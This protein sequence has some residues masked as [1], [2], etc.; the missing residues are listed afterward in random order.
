[1]HDFR[2]LF[3]FAVKV[4]NVLVLMF[5]FLMASKATSQNVTFSDSISI[6][7]TKSR[8]EQL[9]QKTNLSTVHFVKAPDSPINFGIVGSEYNYFLLKLNSLKAGQLIS[10]S[11]VDSYGLRFEI[12]DM[13]VYIQGKTELTRSTILEILKKSGRLHELLLNS[14]L[15]MD[16]AVIAIKSELYELMI[17]GINMKRLVKRFMK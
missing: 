9:I 14:Q 10:D 11:G 3:D 17:D 12:P 6:I 13:L 8:P 5:L 2:L 1:M 15:F 7:T 16:N 4:K